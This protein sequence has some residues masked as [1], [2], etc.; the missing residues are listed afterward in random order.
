M[1]G[2]P[3]Q[4]AGKPRKKA[5]TFLRIFRWGV[6]LAFAGF[7]AFMAV[8]VMVGI[9]ANITEEYPELELPAISSEHRE[10]LTAQQIRDCR[11]A[12]QRMRSEDLD[13]LQAAFHGEQDRDGFLK[14]NEKCFYSAFLLGGTIEGFLHKRMLTVNTVKDLAMFHLFFPSK[15]I[16]R[17]GASSHHF[18]TMPVYI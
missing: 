2:Q 5:W 12:L 3:A 14:E 9:L 13:H 17:S 4:A 15:D 8:C 18:T 6:Y 16:R 11:E 7:M 10:A 1:A